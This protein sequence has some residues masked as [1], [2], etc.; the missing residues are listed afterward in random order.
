MIR[1]EIYYLTVNKLDY[2]KIKD[3]LGYISYRLYICATHKCKIS[4]LQQHNK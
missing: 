1:I 2:M 4:I 3:I